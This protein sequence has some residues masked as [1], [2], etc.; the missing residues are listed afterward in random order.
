MVARN[1]ISRALSEYSSTLEI[2]FRATK[3][4]QF[5]HFFLSQESPRTMSVGINTVARNG[6][7][8]AMSE[9]SFTLE[10]LFRATVKSI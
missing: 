1:S 4:L 8:R 7:S 2:L 9:Y 6:I 10:I 3:K 5:N